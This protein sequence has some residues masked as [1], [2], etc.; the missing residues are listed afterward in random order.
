MQTKTPFL[1][2]FST[3]L[4]G[5]AKR[6]NQDIV[7]AE[8]KRINESGPGQLSQQLQ[9]EIPPTLLASLS[10]TQRIRFY[11]N[12][13]TFWAF[14]GQVISEDQSCARAVSR[15][16]QWFRMK[17]QKMPSSDTSSYCEARQNLP[18]EMLKEVNHHVYRQ[19]DAEL[20]TSSLWR[21]FRILAEDGTSASMPDTATNQ[22]KFPQPSTQAEGC[23]FPTVGLCGLINLGHGG[24]CDF[25]SASIEVSEQKGHDQLKTYLNAEDLL[26]GDRLFSTYEIIAGRIEQGGAYIGRHH[27]ARKIDFRKGRKIGRNQR[28]VTWKKPPQQSSGSCLS[29]AQWRDLPD[30]IDM[31]LIRTKGP[32]REGKQQTFYVVSTL[33]DAIEYPAEEILSLYVHRWEIE[34]AYRDIK[35]TMGM[36]V[37]RTKSP[38]MIEKEILM[39]MIAYN[40]IRLLMLKA[41]NLYGVNHRRIS[42]KGTI[43]ILEE[44]RIN[45]ATI[46]DKPRLRT[47]QK[48]AMLKEIAEGIV[49][50]RPGRNEPR[51]KKRRPK[52][53]GWIQK[54]RHHYFEHFTNEN[55]PRK[56]LDE[57][58]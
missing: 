38:E 46:A 40:L 32:N 23:G 30:E 51:K 3:L 50:E 8:F 31:R 1:T 6:K 29:K 57:C 33:L 14:L 20:P 47:Q 56:I 5:R 45:F 58:P 12:V 39:Y 17:K 53:Y 55:P 10:Q 16:R 2:G 11:S 24:L 4:C 19:L 49:R 44:S 26:I 36:E 25:A 15:V 54:P 7:A 27:Q 22:E 13:V 34:L 28:L 52:S 21:G 42:F 18:I 48:E 9:G 37:L 43:Q 41:G 35:T